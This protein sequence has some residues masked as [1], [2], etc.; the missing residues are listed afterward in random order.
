MVFVALR[1]QAKRPLVFA[2]SMLNLPM[3][4][5]RHPLLLLNHCRC[6]HV[7]LSDL[8]AAISGRYHSG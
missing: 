4:E 7:T 3:G 5:F 1:R 8:K 2:A 6:M